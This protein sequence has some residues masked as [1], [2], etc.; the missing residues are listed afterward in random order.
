MENDIMSII[1]D[2][3]SGKTSPSK[4]TKL[5]RNYNFKK[6]LPRKKASKL[7][8]KIKD[9]DSNK[10]INIPGIPFWLITSLGSLGLTVTK[11][12]ANKSDTLDDETKQYLKILD[13]INIKE[14][15]GELKN[16]GPFDLVNVFEEDGDEVKISIL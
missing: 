2:L 13:E 1:I 10:R 7:K 16:Y 5:I 9:R 12:V 8:I 15:L 3:K 4:A 14:L 6:D 11:L